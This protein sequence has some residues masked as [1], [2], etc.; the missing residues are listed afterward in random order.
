M[1]RTDSNLG[2]GTTIVQTKNTHAQKAIGKSTHAQKTIVKRCYREN[3]SN[4]WLILECLSLF[5]MLWSLHSCHS[6]VA[7]C[8]DFSRPN[9][10]FMQ[11]ISLAEP[12]SYGDVNK[13]KKK[14]CQAELGQTDRPKDREKH[15]I[16]PQAQE[17]LCHKM[18]A[19]RAYGMKFYSS[20]WHRDQMSFTYGFRLLSVSAHKI[21]SVGSKL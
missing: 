15:P 1:T 17:W 8:C 9:L 2:H 19:C 6:S 10:V 7:P 3:V 18:F 21:L 14:H 4:F 5:T 20:L 13:R 16:T 12:I 11:S